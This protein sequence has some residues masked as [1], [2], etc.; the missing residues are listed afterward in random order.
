M[1]QI[2]PTQNKILASASEH[3]QDIKL[4]LQC[5][6]ITKEIPHLAKEKH[7]LCIR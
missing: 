2:F 1:S 5:V 7:K 4:N 3:Y 6:P